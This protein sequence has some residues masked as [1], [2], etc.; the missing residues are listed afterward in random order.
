MLQDRLLRRGTVALTWRGAARYRS[1]DALLCGVLLPS[2]LYPHGF[3]PPLVSPVSGWV[4]L[5]FVTWNGP[6][7][8]RP[9]PKKLRAL[10]VPLF[11]ACAFIFTIRCTMLGRKHWYF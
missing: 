4:G 11:I 5:L 2:Q 8:W 1:P 7:W 9:L 3:L 10:C 6:E